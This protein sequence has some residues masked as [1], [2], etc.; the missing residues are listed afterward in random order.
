MSKPIKLPMIQSLIIELRGRRVILDRDLAMLYQVSTKAL[1]QAV[2]RNKRRFPPDFMFQL[3]RDEYNFLKS[4]IVTSERV[5]EKK[6]KLPWVFTRNGANMISAVLKSP[7]AVSR[8]VQIMRAFSALEDLV[9]RNKRKLRNEPDLLKRLGIHSRAIMHL[10][11]KDKIKGKQIETLKNIQEK[12]IRLLQQ[13]VI[14]SVDDS[15]A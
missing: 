2:K 11:Q 13:I 4:Q 10:F 6:R 3:T 7:I 15:N 14:A 8:S 9:S 1:N 5:P 12:T